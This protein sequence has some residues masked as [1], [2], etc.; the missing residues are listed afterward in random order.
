MDDTFI[1]S[2]VSKKMVASRFGAAEGHNVFLISF[3]AMDK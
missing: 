2:F 3:R 1:I